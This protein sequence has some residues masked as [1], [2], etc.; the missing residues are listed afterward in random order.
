LTALFDC[1]KIN[2]DK[3]DILLFRVYAH[4]ALHNTTIIIIITILTQDV[5]RNTHIQIHYAQINTHIIVS[6]NEH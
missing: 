5:T 1:D 4:D 6:N 2:Y 3:L